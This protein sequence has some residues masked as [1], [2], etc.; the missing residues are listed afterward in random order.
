M[1][2]LLIVHGFQGDGTF[3]VNAGEVVSKNID[4]SNQSR[5]EREEKKNDIS[6]F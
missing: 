6:I 3:E 5:K 4:R 2:G 1:R